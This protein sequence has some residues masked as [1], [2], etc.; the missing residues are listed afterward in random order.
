MQRAGL[1]GTISMV[2][3]SIE[4][5]TVRPGVNT[6]NARNAQ[7]L[8][9]FLS[10]CE[11]ELDVTAELLSETGI[12]VEWCDCGWCGGEWFLAWPKGR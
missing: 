12:T 3:N 6:Q 8:A 7:T 1:E 9:A 2:T 11:E 5:S 4:Y 10:R